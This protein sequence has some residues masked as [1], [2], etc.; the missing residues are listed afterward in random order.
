MALAEPANPALAASS[1][2]RAASA[3]PSIGALC[4]ASQA[5]CIDLVLIWLSSLTALGLRFHPAF[6]RCMGIARPLGRADLGSNAGFLLLYSVL[7]VLLLNAQGLYRR[8]QTLSPAKERGI[9]SRAAVLAALLEAACIGLTGLACLSGFVVASATLMAAVFLAG[10]HWLRR[11]RMEN[12]LPDGWSCRNVLIVG[13]GRL[14]L[15]LGAYLERHRRLG[16]RVRGLVAC[17]PEP[18]GVQVETLG[19]LSELRV[20]ART[21]FIDEVL[22]A[23]PEQNVI[24]RVLFEV[25]G[26]RVGVRVVPYLYDDWEGEAPVEYVG[27]FPALVLQQRPRRAAGLLIK[28]ASDLVLTAIALAALSPVFLLVAFAV[29]LSSPGAAI[30]ASERVGRKGRIFRCYKFRTMIASADA[31]KT[32]LQHLNQRDR[33]LFKIANDPRTTSV[34]RF[35]RKY[36]LD[37]LPQLWNVL[38]GEM[39][40]VGPRPPL[41]SE[42]R[43]YEL[44]HLRRLDVLPGITGLWQVEARSNPS[45][46]RYVSLDVDYVEHWS[47]WL[48]ARILFKTI[49]VVLAGTGQ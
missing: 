1:A 8:Q 47:S 39:S 15:A 41:A 49:A 4:R 26:L 7:L 9:I 10:W 27:N 35:L 11:R 44:D 14:A 6:V 31:L 29:K 3:L 40:L 21:Y 37:E 28:R 16:Y 24:Q 48:D 18:R 17:E 19:S 22:V 2:L 43:Q 32:S 45:F 38:K 34:G 36:S 42:V 46:A 33:V 23:A 5:V 30:Y 25:G 12:A 13:T 20:L